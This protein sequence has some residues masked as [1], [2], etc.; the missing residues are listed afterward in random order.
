MFHVN[1]AKTSGDPVTVQVTL[2]DYNPLKMEV[3][4]GAAVSVIS[5]DTFHTVFKD[6]RQL[7]KTQVTL[8]TYLGEEI[9]VLGQAVVNVKYESQ[10]V[11]NLPLMITIGQGAS[12]FG[13]NWLQHVRLN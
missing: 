8:R 3:D 4:M 12:L 11:N 6:T 7:E 13:R 1:S 2:N 9:P 5:E 10:T